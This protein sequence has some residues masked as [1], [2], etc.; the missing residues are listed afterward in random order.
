MNAL[1]YYFNEVTHCNMCGADVHDHKV[2]GQRLNQSQ[3]LRPKRK[4]GISVSVMKCTS[5]GLIY[6]NPQPVPFDIQDHYGVPP[7]E[8]WTPD[9]FIIDPNYFSDV[10]NKSKKFLP[11]KPGMKALD[12]GAGIG[13]GMIAM[14]NAGYSACGLEPSTPFYERAI[15]VMGIKPESLVRGM[16]EEVNHQPNSFDFITFSSVLEHLYDADKAIARTMNWLKPGGLIHIEVPSVNYLMSSIYN[17]YYRLRGTNYVTNTSPMHSPFHL[18][19]FSLKSFEENQKKN[20]YSIAH[21]EY[22]VC[23]ILN[24]PKVFHPFLKW[25]MKVTNR[26][27]QLEIWLRKN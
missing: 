7:E 25:Y 20:H 5:C 22:K 26:G 15:N 21:F 4:K 19:E 9:Y 23:M 17:F 8:Y 6:N 10:I 18:Y 2:M 14:E 3:G 11:F 13:H 12:I 24:F 1:R 16:V 27:M